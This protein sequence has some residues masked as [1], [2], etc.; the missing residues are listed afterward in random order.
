MGYIL[1]FNGVLVQVDSPDLGKTILARPLNGEKLT[2]EEV[3]DL[4]R[5]LEVS[6]LFA[7]NIEIIS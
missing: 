1:G 4:R 7:E 5:A 2:E 6:H 3:R